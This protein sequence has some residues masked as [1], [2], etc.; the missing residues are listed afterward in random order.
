MYSLLPMVRPDASMRQGCPDPMKQESFHRLIKGMNPIRPLL[1]RQFP[2]KL[3]PQ[4][5]K[6]AFPMGKDT[7]KKA[8][9]RR[10]G[11][12]P[13]HPVMRML[14]ALVPRARHIR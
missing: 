7:L 2:E 10:A 9:L 1:Y 11:D 3:K 4:N 8:S 12:N 6:G 13:L 14:R 5:K